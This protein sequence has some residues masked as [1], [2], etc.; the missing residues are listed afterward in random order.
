MKKAIAT[1]LMISI[2]ILLSQNN[3]SSLQGEW[4]FESMTTITKAAREEITIVYKDKNNVETLTFS[5]SG[6]ILYNVLNEGIQKTGHGVWYS[7]ES[8]VTIIVESDTTYGTYGIEDGY[9]TIIITEEE[10]DEYYG[11]STILKYSKQ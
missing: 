6:S 3:D 8:Y 11:Y 2:A 5:N 1:Y 9:L 10:S 4:V 7:D